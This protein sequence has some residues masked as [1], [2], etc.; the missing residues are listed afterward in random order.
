[1]T[2][3]AQVKP[4]PP[5]SDATLLEV[6]GLVKHFPLTRGIVFKHKIGDV[7]AVDGISLR[8]EA[9]Q[10]H[11]LVGES[12]CGKSTTGR[13]ILRLHEPT[14]GSI[15]FKGREVSKLGSHQMQR[16]RRDMQIIFQ[17][18]Y[19][20]LN[21]RMTIRDIVS[22]PWVIHG[23]HSGERRER[24]EALLERVG[25]NPEPTATRTCSRVGNGS[26]SVWL[27]LWPWNHL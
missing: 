26:A 21:P 13:T 2:D 20:S 3:T 24:A 23:L 14:A 22:E 15:R 5:E 19:A 27:E 10:T 25:L 6:R 9:G 18:P 1:M 12:G 8:V 4:L 16:I 11:G 7:K 17:D